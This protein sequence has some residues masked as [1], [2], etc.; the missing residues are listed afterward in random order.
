MNSS[1]S[2][3]AG[4]LMLVIVLVSVTSWEI[5][6]RKK[7]VD[8]SYDEGPSL[9]AHERGRV[10]Q[11]SD[12]AVVVIGSSRIK[13]DIDIPTWENTTHTNLV[14]LACI[15]STPIPVLT[16]LANDPAFKGRLIV[17]VTEILFF[18]NNPFFEIRPTSGLKNYKDRSPAQQ[19]S[20][21]LDRLVESQL[22]FL[23]KDNFSLNAE[24][25]KLEIKNRP[26]YFAMPLFPMEFERTRFNRQSYMT[27]KLVADT[28]LRNRVMGIWDFLGN[29]MRSAP[30]MTA[31]ETEAIF[32][33]VKD[34]VAKIKARGGDVIFT[35][36][37]SSGRFYMGESMG[38]PREKFWD[39]L[40]TVTGCQGIYF[41][42]YPALRDFIC[43]EN[44]HLSPAQAI[45]YTKE[46][47]NIL[48]TEKGWKFNNTSTN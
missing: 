42:D 23:D 2:A 26:G 30:P 14:Q 31:E 6:L 21:Q 22:V 18:N 4:L 35:R 5:Y 38:Y 12:K 29:A 24:L 41:K 37:P 11:S 25:D 16:D 40:L 9:F 43:P 39:K 48:E 33:T 34:D 28:N 1:S 7:G 44:S 32:S 13:Y 19:A 27:D 36:T 15:G 10:Y 3:K 46:V 8:T 20:L 45:E 47:I 17:D